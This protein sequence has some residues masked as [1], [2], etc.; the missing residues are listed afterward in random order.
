MLASQLI[1]S[2][3]PVVHLNDRVSFALQLMED[4]E[5]QHLPVLNEELF[6]GMIDKDDL[7]DADEKSTLET[8]EYNIIKIS[9]SPEQHFLLALKVCTGF[10]LTIVP[11]IS[12][13]KELLGIITQKDLLSAAGNFLGQDET[14]GIIEMEIEKR[15]FSFGELSRLVETNN[16]FITQLNTSTNSITGN[17]VVTIKLNKFEISDIIATLQR[18]DYH[19]TFYH[20]EELFENELRENYDMLMTYLRI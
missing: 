11:V 18:Y 14:G 9:V 2:K 1:Q 19:I 7:L 5:M 3:Y 6:F 10:G 20:G 4:Y 8:L 12:K 17:L 16:A 15:N 13:E